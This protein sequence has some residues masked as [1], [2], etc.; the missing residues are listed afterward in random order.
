[1]QLNQPKQT[2]GQERHYNAE[3][4]S[5]QKQSVYLSAKKIAVTLFLITVV[6]LVL[7]MV[8]YALQNSLPASVA[9]PL[10]GLFNLSRENNFPTYFSAFLLLFSGLFAL[11][12]YQYKKSTKAKFRL[13]WMLLGLV[14]I[15]LS[16]DEAVQIHERLTKFTAPKFTF[17]D[18]AFLTFAWVIPYTILFLVVAVYF[19]KFVL[20]LPNRTR[21][22][23]IASGILF[24]GGA[25]GFEFIESYVVSHNGFNQLYWWLATVEEVM[26]ITGVIVLVYALLDY[27]KTAG[28]QLSI[29]N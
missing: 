9:E 5:H 22:L 8:V 28:I 18:S 27:I 7:H 4:D 26:E 6:L 11:V 15:F 25:L 23:F 10:D 3:L 17:L 14:L 20:S 1:M 21:N 16:L 2:I 13:Q 19:L 29:K 12:I 24:I